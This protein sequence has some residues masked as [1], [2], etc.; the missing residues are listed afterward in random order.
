MASGTLLHLPVRLLQ[1]L[2]SARVQPTPELQE[3]SASIR[4]VGVLQP[5]TVE[6]CGNRFLVISGNRRLAAAR[7][8]GLETVP[9]LTAEGEDRDRLL[10]LLDGALHGEVA[11]REDDQRGL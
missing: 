8:A 9:C 10:R 4:E 2:P 5:L 11:I 7:M 1:S 3:L 6:R